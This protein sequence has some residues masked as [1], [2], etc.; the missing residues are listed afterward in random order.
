VPL[1]IRGGQTIGVVDLYREGDADGWS[2]EEQAL[3]ASMAEQIADSIE[4]ER[5]FEQTQTSLAEAERLYEAS[6]RISAAREGVETLQVV[7]DTVSSTAVDQVAIWM[8]DRPLTDRG[9]TR[10]TDGIATAQDVQEI[11]TFWDRT[12]TEPPVPLGTK[13]TAEQYPL[14]NKLSP[15]DPFTISDIRVD[16]TL[17]DRFRE[18]LLQAGFYAVA[19]VPISVG[20]EWLGYVVSMVGASH[21]FTPE[22]LRVH[23]A[24]SDQAAIALRSQRLLRQAESRARRETLIR[25]ITSKM[26]SSPDLDTILN[27]AVQELGQA[28]GVSRAFVRLSIPGEGETGS[29]V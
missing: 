10:Q 8:F 26:R 11:V 12:G 24:V 29:D 22:E 27:T 7:L 15:D 5:L 16:E 21:T 14:V 13:C 1:T 23:R 19:A 9:E 6:R 28:L 25:E 20:N 2:E 4:G 18:T 3:I 17:D